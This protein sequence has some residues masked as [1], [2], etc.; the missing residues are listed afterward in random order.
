MEH[1]TLNIIDN[2][3]DLA[4]KE[5]ADPN[6]RIKFA[7]VNIRDAA[8]ELDYPCSDTLG[9]LK[10]LAEM[11]LLNNND[12]DALD[13]SIC[14]ENG[15][16]NVND[17]LMTLIPASEFFMCSDNYEP[18]I[19]LYCDDTEFV[20][21]A[22][23]CRNDALNGI[24]VSKGSEDKYFILVGGNTRASILF[25]KY[26]NGLLKNADDTLPFDIVSL[27]KFKKSFPAT[28][29]INK[30]SSKKAI[31]TWMRENQCAYEFLMIKDNTFFGHQNWPE[32][33]FRSA[34]SVIIEKYFNR[35]Y[36]R[37]CSIED[38]ISSQT[39][40][41]KSIGL[42]NERV[43]NLCM[44]ACLRTKQD[45]LR[46]I[47]VN[48]SALARASYF[49]EKKP[50]FSRKTI[51]F[52]RRMSNCS[53]KKT[54]E[55]GLDID[56]KTKFFNSVGIDIYT[57][58]VTDVSKL[59]RFLNALAEAILEFKKISKMTKSQELVPFIWDS[60]ENHGEQFADYLSNDLINSFGY[61]V[62]SG[63][64]DNATGLLKAYDSLLETN[65][66][67]REEINSLLLKLA[68][69]EKAGA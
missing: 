28:V 45:E 60:F 47:Q 68:A 49:N 29:K 8:K 5:L 46:F 32:H 3:L 14:S 12:K 6:G 40:L 23:K 38:F 66:N 2:S 39:G 31:D 53:S 36:T 35:F 69:Y 55:S 61:I 27:E 52:F 56:L 26:H 57:M 17:R 58:T 7:A 54:K 1:D 42:T 30:N 67:L 48:N 41:F 9:K 65:K 4:I 18:Q 15:G 50:W 62:G 24:A 16:Y 20:D 37:N 10:F 59:D 43:F 51:E 13:E 21:Y 33:I 64:K 25:N 44:L 63:K 22:T 34:I 11:N 19:H